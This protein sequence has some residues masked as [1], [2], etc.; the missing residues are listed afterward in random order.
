[1][2]VCCS[3]PCR[4]E[5]ANSCRSRCWRR[6][7]STKQAGGKVVIV[8]MDLQMGE[9]AL[10]LNLVSQFSVLDALRNEDRLDSDFLSSLLVRHTSGLSVLAAPEQY[11]PF[12]SLSSGVKKVF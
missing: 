6:P 2:P 10:G 1:M 8:D 4:L 7:S 12:N 9:A 3:D 11:T 5:L